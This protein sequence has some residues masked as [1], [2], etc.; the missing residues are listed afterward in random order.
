M[1]SFFRINFYLYQMLS[2]LIYVV[3]TL[4][5]FLFLRGKKCYRE[6]IIKEWLLLFKVLMF[7]GFL[8]ETLKRGLSSR[9]WDV[10]L[11]VLTGSCICSRIKYD[12]Q[13][14]SNNWRFRWMV[15]SWVYSLLFCPYLSPFNSYEYEHRHFFWAWFKLFYLQ[16]T[17]FPLAH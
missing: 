11:F 10:F 7:L 3:L 16:N 17:R 12:C 13:V 9:L 2:I 8:K 4:V 5:S 6:S 1:C 14:R 15:H